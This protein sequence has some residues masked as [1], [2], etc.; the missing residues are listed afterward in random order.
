MKK[1]ARTKPRGTSTKK[2]VQRIVK[3][4]IAE[5]LASTPKGAWKSWHQLWEESCK[6]GNKL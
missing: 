5:T 2:A 3:E 1:T 4:S 6:T